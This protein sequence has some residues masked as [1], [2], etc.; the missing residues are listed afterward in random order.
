MRK[1]LMVKDF[2]FKQ[3]LEVLRHDYSAEF[4]ADI[5]ERNILRSISSI[6]I[7]AMYDPIASI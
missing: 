3:D 4:N 7:K 1:E 6:L 5:I 2:F